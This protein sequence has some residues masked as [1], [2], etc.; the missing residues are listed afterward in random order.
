MK[1]L[2]STETSSYVVFLR[3]TSF[4]EKSTGSN[5]EDD[6]TTTEEDDGE[7]AAAAAAAGAVAAGAA[8]ATDAACAGAAGAAAAAAAGPE[9][10][11]PLGSGF[12]RS[13][14][15]TPARSRRQRDLMTMARREGSSR[16]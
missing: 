8:V 1:S 16:K 9:V 12:S 10:M 4:G 14:V 11:S 2:A 5:Y 6:A 3:H 13:E 15:S 7:A